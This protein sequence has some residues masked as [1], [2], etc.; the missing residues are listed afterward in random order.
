M[1]TFDNVKRSVN[2]VNNVIKMIFNHVGLKDSELLTKI[3]VKV[4]QN[5]DLSIEITA[6]E[7]IT[8]VDSGR[9][10]GKM[11]PFKQM[12]DWVLKNKDKFKTK[13]IRNGSDTSEQS[14]DVRLK[15]ITFAIMK[16]IS[17]KGTKGYFFMDKLIKE[18]FELV[19]ANVN[20]DLDKILQDISK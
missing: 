7:Y 13:Q 3:E 20:K 2:E 1:N 17:L 8:F 9:K 14:D 11:P 15:S 12:Y 16:N 10:A 6:P 4:V 5:S 18:V 19:F